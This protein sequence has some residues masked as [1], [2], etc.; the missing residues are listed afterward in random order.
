MEELIIIT[1]ILG[2]GYYFLTR[3]KEEIKEEKPLTHS[4]S[5]QTEPIIPTNSEK[6]ERKALESTIDELIKEIRKLNHSIK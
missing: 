1:L 3:N 2:T 4:Q 5:I 6:E